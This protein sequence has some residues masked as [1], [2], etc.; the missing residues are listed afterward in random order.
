[1]FSLNKKVLF[2]NCSPSLQEII[3]RKLKME[4][5]APSLQ[6]IINRLIKYD[7]LSP[8]VQ[9]K[10]NRLIG[11]SDLDP[12]LY[13]LITT[14][15]KK[16]F[17]DALA[18]TGSSSQVLV[19]DQK[20]MKLISDDNF[21]LI[22]VVNNPDD[23]EIMKKLGPINLKEIF[24]TWHR[25][26]QDT[27][28]RPAKEMFWKTYMIDCPS[29]G[30][31]FTS[32]AGEDYQNHPKDSSL[33]WAWTYDDA[34]K[35]VQNN[36]NVATLTGFISTYRYVEYWIEFSIRTNQQLHTGEDYCGVVIS[37]IKD[38]NGIE[39]TLSLIRCN[40]SG[41]GNHGPVDNFHFG[42]AYDIYQRT[43]YTI[44]RADD[45]ITDFPAFCQQNNNGQK[46]NLFLQKSGATITAKTTNYA[47][48]DPGENWVC[49]FSWTLP[50]SKP[51]DWPLTMW[52]NITKMI[53]ESS[54]MGF[55]ALS[56]SCNFFIKNQYMVFEDDKIYNLGDNSVW[57]YIN[58]EWI[59][60]GKIG[61]NLPNRSWLYNRFTKQLYWY[62][63]NNEYY[64]INL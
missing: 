9:A 53:L 52:N 2:E 27:L 62:K 47:D 31:C 20:H 18:E 63:Y 14:N 6:A 22:R 23:F 12:N 30:V 26:S 17:I 3:M 45:L 37:W 51:N 49:G 29:D 43:C 19:T 41:I 56:Y 21:H 38:S 10:I 55:W 59:K 4:D 7:D 15:S 35:T 24:N 58:D 61:D 32:D 46:C 33:V 44:Y 1:M 16:Y 25:F 39:H 48:N 28:Y 50:A 34:T 64:E 11:L 5:L 42:L 40:N 60:I 57:A 8:E 13:T 54:C 36:G